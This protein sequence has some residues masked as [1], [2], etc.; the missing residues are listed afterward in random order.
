M[1]SREFAAIPVVVALLGFVALILLAVT[2]GAWAWYLLLACAVAGTCLLIW[3]C[4]RRHPHPSKDAAPTVAPVNDG[5]FRVLVVADG[6]CS[7]DALES[8]IVSRSAGRPAQALVIVPTLSSRLDWLTGDENAY[9]TAQERLAGVLELLDRAGVER[10]GHIG[11]HDPVQAA[12]DGLREFAADLVVF[13]THSADDRSQP[14]LADVARDR[15][16]IPVAHIY[17]TP[18]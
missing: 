4:L 9:Q 13:V 15:Y 7:L 8:E 2:I 1:R 3:W 17:S 10:D 18:V 6:S 12:D 16:G 14:G 5:M 11:A